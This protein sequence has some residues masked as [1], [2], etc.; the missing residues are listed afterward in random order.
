[1]NYGHHEIDAIKEKKREESYLKKKRSF[2]RADNSAMARLYFYLCE[3]F[4]SSF[5]GRNI[6]EVG[7]GR[8]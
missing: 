4:P 3:E 2:F 7:F 1:M 5:Q 8:G 6:V